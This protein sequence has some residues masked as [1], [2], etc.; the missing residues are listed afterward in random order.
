MEKSSYIYGRNAVIEALSAE[1]EIEKIFVQFGTQGDAVNKIFKMAKSQGVQC[2]SYDKKK[3]QALEK[4]IFARVGKDNLKSFKDNKTQGI[5][6]LMRSFSILSIDEFIATINDTSSNPMIVVLDEISDPH[7][8]GAIARTAECAGAI[9][10]IMTERNSAPITPA[11]I[12]ASAG[13]LEHIPVVKVGN[14]VTAFEKLKE[15]G[16]WIVGTDGEGKNAYTDDIYNSPTA[17]V[18]GSE[19]KGLRPSVAKHCDFIVRIPLMGNISSLNASVSSAIVMYEVL[20]QKLA[21][22]NAK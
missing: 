20:R 6:A 14:L 2:V 22:Q 21:K 18:I 15:I 19:G 5:I 17:I 12:K 4:D 10:L 7:N 13:A 9:G 11:A 3:F 16:F 1:K 8:L